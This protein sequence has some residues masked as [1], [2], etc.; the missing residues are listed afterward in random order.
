MALVDIDDVVASAELRARA[1]QVCQYRQPLSVFDWCVHSFITKTQVKIWSLDR[2]V[3]AMQEWCPS[4]N[5]PV[6]QTAHVIACNL[7]GGSAQSTTLAQAT[8]FVVAMPFAHAIESDDDEDADDESLVGEEWKKFRCGWLKKGVRPLRPTKNGDGGAEA[9]CILSGRVS[10]PMNWKQWRT[11]LCKSIM[12]LADDPVWQSCLQSCKLVHTPIVLHELL[13]GPLNGRLGIEI[14]VHSAL[15]AGAAL[16]A[17]TGMS[18]DAVDILKPACGDA[19]KSDVARKILGMLPIEDITLL[20]SNLKAA[21]DRAKAMVDA[22]T[23]KPG[24]TPVNK[25]VQVRMDLRAR[26]ALGRSILAFKARTKS[27]HYAKEFAQKQLGIAY[28]A[29]LSKRFQNAVKLAQTNPW[30]GGVGRGRRARK[31]ERVA[32]RARKN[33]ISSQGRPRKASAVAEL[34][35]QW[36]VDIRGSLKAR[37]PQAVVIAK[38]KSLNAE[39]ALEAAKAGVTTLN[40]AAI[41][42]SWVYRWRLQYGICFKKPNRR[43]TM[44]R[45]GIL[46]RLQIFWRNLFAVRQFSLRRLGIDI[47]LSVENLD[48]KGWHVN[49]LG[50]R[51]TGTLELAGSNPVPLKENHS[52]TRERL[53]FMTWT[54]NDPHRLQSGLPLEAC[55]KSKGQGQTI[56]KGL[57]V[58]KGMSVRISESG[59]Y[60][61]EHVFCCLQMH[62]PPATPERFAANDWRILF[63]DIYSGHLSRRIFELAWDRMYLLMFH[64]G[65]LTGLCQPNDTWLHWAFERKML[66]LEAMDTLQSFLLNPHGV[67]TQ[68]RQTILDNAAAVWDNDIEHDRSIKACR[69]IGFSLALDGSEARTLR[70]V[71]RCAAQCC[72]ALYSLSRCIVQCTRILQHSTVQS[73]IC[74][75]L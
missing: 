3:V 75:A 53:T 42:S 2:D 41:N 37:L 49:Q 27:R 57:R 40:L 66:A 54:S 47:G 43:Y 64:G 44:S 7:A 59:S 68:S 55:F 60:K 33:I 52:A 15:A 17:D 1:G 13:E 39:Y 11:D 70:S 29:T 31:D 72:T 73:C 65:G 46:L 12:G 6:W 19:L 36:F 25:K 14:D 24:A 30:L 35:F 10:S 18:T 48:Q 23:S 51:N 20:R 22:D 9:G 8:D 61:E 26:V 71:L 50:S 32:L 28:S 45:S 4:L 62:L 38:A 34:L 69:S 21:Q 16:E 74:I 56:L 67:P 5:Q 63:L 58:P